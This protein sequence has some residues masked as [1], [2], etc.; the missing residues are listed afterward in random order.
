MAWAYAVNI[1]AQQFLKSRSICADFE[2]V[3]SVLIFVA[4][5]AKY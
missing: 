3:D 2:R 4:Q 1:E 5:K